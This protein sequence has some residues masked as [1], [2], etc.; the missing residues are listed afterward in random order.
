[1]EI[2]KYQE[3]LLAQAPFLLADNAYHNAIKEAFLKTP[4]HLF[5]SRFRDTTRPVWNTVT[6]ENLPSLLPVL[7]ANKALALYDGDD[8]SLLSSISQPHIVLK[9]LEL[10]ELEPGNT[11]FEIGAASG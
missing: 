3:Q 10:L 11:V 9:M 1:M 5:V 8:D 4:R 6:E 2:R 7:Y